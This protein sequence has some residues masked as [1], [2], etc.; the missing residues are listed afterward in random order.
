MTEALLSISLYNH[1]LSIEL[2][3]VSPWA[4]QFVPQSRLKETNQSQDKFQ[5]S[6]II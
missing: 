2:Y 6:S 4:K 3:T 5:S 1:S